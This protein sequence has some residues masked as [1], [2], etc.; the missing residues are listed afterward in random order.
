MTTPTV[1]SLFAPARP[2]LRPAVFVAREKL[3]E[4]RQKLRAQHDSGSLGIQVCTLLSAMLDDVVVGLY[5]SNLADLEPVLAQRLRQ[6]IALVPFGGFGRGEIA[7][8]SDV[9]LM[10]L[11]HPAVASSVPTLAKRIVTD[12]GDAG[13]VLGFCSRTI[14]QACKLAQDD[15]TILTSLAEAR[16]L[17]G[18]RELFD[19]FAARFKRQARMR[20]RKL[21]PLVE[22][23]RRE[24]RTKYGETV[25]LLEPNIKRSRGGL[26]DL[27]LI[28]WLGFI[29][30]GERDPTALEL[31]GHLSRRDFFALRDATEFLLRLRNEMHFHAGKSQDLLGRGEQMRLA[32]LFGYRGTSGVLPVERFMQDYFRHTTE[33]RNIAANFTRNCRP[34]SLVSLLWEPLV[35]VNMEGDFRLG[36]SGISANR[37]GLRKLQ[38]DLSQVLRLMDLAAM[39]NKRIDDRTWETIRRSMLEAD[40]IEPNDEAIARFLSLLAQTSQ[41][42]DSLRR[43]HELGVLEKLVPGFTHARNLLQF[44]QYHKLTVDA[45]CIRAV[46]VC[47][48]FQQHQGRIGQV[49]RSI[50]QKRTLHLALLIH[51]LGKGFVEDHS[52]V[53]LRIADE[54]AQRL[55]LGERETE[56]LKFL[57]HKHLTMSHLAFRRDTSDEEVVVK[58]A[59]ECGSPD[60]LKMLYVLTASDLGSVGPG[61][62][63]E[64]KLDVLTELYHRTMRH[65]AGNALFD[66]EEHLRRRRDAVRHHIPDDPHATWFHKQIDA[67]PPGYLLA[68]PPLQIADDLARLRELPT[69]SASAWGR[70]LPQQRVVEFTI[71]AYDQISPGLFH[72]L[73]GALTSARLQ[74]LAAEI[75]T[76][77]D[78]LVLDRFYVQDHEHSA[79]PPDER[80]EALSQNLIAAALDGS[81]AP[82][83]FTKLWSMQAARSGEFARLPTRV[84][85]DN[86]TSDRFTVID[87]F[88]HDRMGLLYSITRTIFEC[89]ASVGVAKV[90]TYLDQVVDV[91]YVTDQATG[92]KITSESRLLEIRHRLLAAIDSVPTT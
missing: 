54:T 49:Y 79:A 41:L 15:A 61:V 36:P 50:K 65:L 85:L 87:V 7:P 11:Y 67:L 19:R 77:A 47:T 86:D 16:F 6:H 75:N 29:V 82:P 59:V 53:G 42:A 72:R 35:A 3:A 57:V 23:A 55:K 4:S 1:P 12:V 26:R 66:A 17:A 68:C 10:L 39:A 22:Q 32:E 5:E 81:N 14:D 69:T 84:R 64:W 45:H 18:S 28:R 62:L 60:V 33:V 70:F 58:F 46:E 21:V 88:C 52:D 24:E 40:G 83:R 89:G 2:L 43:L 13:L 48:E 51:D 63:N 34:R 25:F 37:R 30:H 90:G 80:L 78:G 74:I 27:Q 91:F 44:N 76:L 31:A 73:T 92:A 38:G 8:Y 20:W 9:D 71:G 56:T